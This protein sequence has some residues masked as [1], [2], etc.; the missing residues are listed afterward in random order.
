MDYI[1]KTILY[2]CSNFRDI[3]LEEENE[4][5]VAVGGGRRRGRAGGQQ[6]EREITGDSMGMNSRL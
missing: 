1:R 4:P 3:L 5:P 6:R 2:F